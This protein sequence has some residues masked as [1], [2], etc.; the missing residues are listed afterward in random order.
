MNWEPKAF[1]PAKVGKVPGEM[2]VS[3][4][5]CDPTIHGQNLVLL[6]DVD[7]VMDGHVEGHVQRFRRV[8]HWPHARLVIGQQVL[9][10]SVLVLPAECTCAKGGN[11]IELYNV[12]SSTDTYDT[13]K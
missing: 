13:S 4:H 10:Q 12:Y 11:N 5:L 7:N 6:I 9:G 1:D 8:F 2:D 3:P